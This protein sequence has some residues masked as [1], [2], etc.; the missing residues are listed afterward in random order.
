MKK[1]TFFVVL[2]LL[3]TGCNLDDNFVSSSDPSESEVSHI[4][5]VDEPSG[6]EQENPDALD[7]WIAPIIP[8]MPDD[9]IPIPK[10]LWGEEVHNLFWIKEMCEIFDVEYDEKMIFLSGEPDY[11]AHTQLNELTYGEVRRYTGSITVEGNTSIP[12]V[13]KEFQSIR[14]I[15]LTSTNQYALPPELF[16]LTQLESLSLSMANIGSI[17]PEIKNMTGLKSLGLFYNNIETLPPELFEM[18]WLEKLYITDTDI[19]LEDYPNVYLKELPHEI[20]NLSN[21]KVLVINGCRLE[22]IPDELWT[23]TNLE[24]LDLRG[25]IFPEY[26]DEISLLPNLKMLNGKPVSPDASKK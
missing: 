18:T 5:N 6:L 23:L 2:L 21:L 11:Y 25:N 14:S 22:S 16:E 8:E 24:E 1:L 12:P 17:P 20:D 9:D 7:A 10:A 26:P 3:F 13:I 4:A 15:Y 19:V